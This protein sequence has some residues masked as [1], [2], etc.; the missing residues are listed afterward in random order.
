MVLIIQNNLPMKNILSLEEMAM[1]LIIQNNLK[2]FQMMTQHK[3][4]TLHKVMM[5]INQSEDI[6]I[7]MKT[8]IPNQL[9]QDK[10]RRKVV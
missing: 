1:V 8:K 6:L 2:I 9:T 7:M 10:T 3:I 5:T 4:L